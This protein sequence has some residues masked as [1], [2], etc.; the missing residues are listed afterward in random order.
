LYNNNNNKKPIVINPLAV[1]IGDLSQYNYD[2]NYH[3]YHFDLFCKLLQQFPNIKLKKK[4]NG[5]TD[6]IYPVMFLVCQQK[7]P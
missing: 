6:R 3:R 5:N 7:R 4:K 1:L 2:P